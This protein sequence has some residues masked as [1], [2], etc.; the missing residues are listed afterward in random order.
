MTRPALPSD[1][2]FNEDGLIPAIVQDHLTGEVRMMAWMNAEAVEATLR[3]GKATFYSRSRQRLWIKGETSGHE[4]RVRRVLAD[5]DRDTLLVLC[6]PAGPSCHTGKDNCFFEP[7]EAQPA[8]GDAAT[9]AAL[10][11]EAHEPAL[12]LLGTLERVLEAR[13]QSTGEKSYTRSLFDGGVPKIGSKI[14][15]EAGELVVALGDETD[16]RVAS[17]AA[18]VLYHV[19]VGL[20]HR[21]VSWRSVLGVLAKRLGVSGHAEKASRTK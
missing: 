9:P 16:E 15:E 3:T 8:A 2:K 6:D 12:P 7:L 4:L 21:N 13:K 17:E 20:R 14:T 10:P 19:L 1:L 11:E 5:C 18:D